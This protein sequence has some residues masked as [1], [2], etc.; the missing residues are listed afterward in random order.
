MTHWVFISSTKRFRMNDWLE[1]NDCVE[2]LQRNR[3]QVNDI[4]YLYTTAPVKRIEYKMIVERIDVPFQEIIDDSEYSLHSVSSRQFS[5]NDLFVRLRLL[6]KTDS[7]NLHLDC[8]RNHGLNAS[9]QSAFKV[10]GELVDYIE[11]QF[12]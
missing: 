1:N 2:Y 5:K 8:L 10:S 3:L 12:K 6:K 4:V 9:M 11:E 7:L